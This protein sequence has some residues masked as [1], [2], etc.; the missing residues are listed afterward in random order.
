MR[1][2]VFLQNGIFVREKAFCLVTLYCSNKRK[3]YK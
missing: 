1:K 2:L 3:T